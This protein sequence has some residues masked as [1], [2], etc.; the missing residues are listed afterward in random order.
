MPSVFRV[1]NIAS[2]AKDILLFRV[3]I[4]VGQTYDLMRIPWITEE[5][6]RYSITRDALKRRLEY[7]DIQVV[8]STINMAT[9]APDTREFLLSVGIDVGVIP[10]SSLGSPVFIRVDNDYTAK[11]TDHII[12][13]NTTNGDVT[14]TL[15]NPASAPG[16]KYIINKNV[17][18]DGSVFVVAENGQI[19]GDN[20]QEFNVFND[21]LV[22]H[23]TGDTYIIG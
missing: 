18:V 22:V 4:R 1:K 19:G 10:G 20:E 8:E 9:Y 7:P 23:S 16:A 13:V 3:K 2:P 17:D 6:I 21:S 12:L 11:P 15:P 5:D 14:V